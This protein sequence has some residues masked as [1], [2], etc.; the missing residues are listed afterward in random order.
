MFSSLGRAPSAS[1][2]APPSR[3]L[4][5]NE[6]RILNLRKFASIAT[7]AS[8]AAPEE[9]FGKLGWIL[10]CPILSNRFCYGRTLFS[11]KLD[12]PQQ[13]P[14]SGPYYWPSLR[15]SLI[16]LS[17]KYRFNIFS[18]LIII[19][20]KLQEWQV[21]QEIV[22]NFR[23]ENIAGRHLNYLSEYM[24]KKGILDLKT[25]TENPRA[26][27]PL[28]ERLGPLK[29]VCRALKMNVGTAKCENT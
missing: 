4:H 10:V 5:Y 7:C 28:A 11:G 22:Q 25:E 14:V 9:Y 12:F 19:L 8:K 18:L 3:T 26:V 21:T 6:R 27:R 13:Q 23:R 2:S 15:V 17:S 1:L 20:R 16:L 29:T 24:I